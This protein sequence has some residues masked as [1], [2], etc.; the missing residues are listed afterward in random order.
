MLTT[1]PSPTLVNDVRFGYAR[2]AIGV[3]T[4]NQTITNTSVGL[5]PFGSNPRD[6]G[7]SV[8]SISGVSP[9][10]DDYTTP[11][12][13]ATDSFQLVDA[14]SWSRGA[15]LVK[16]GGEWTA[17][18]QRAFRDVQ[19]RGFL[20]FVDRG[21]S[22]NA[23]ADVLLGLPALT[24]G[25]TLDNPQRL[26]AMNWG[27]FVQDEWRATPS[28]SISA[29]VRYDYAA[30]PVDADDRASLYDPATSG[31]VPV[32]SGVPRGGYDPDRN[33]V[34]PR[35]GF[36]WALDRDAVNVLRG[37]Y[38]IYLNVGALVPSEGPYFNP[39]DFVPGVFFPAPGLP[40]PTPRDLLPA[41]CP[42][43]PPSAGR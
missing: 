22:G 31:L 41:C 36:A 3:T 18:R 27:M 42:P 15:H 28:L 26:R 23:L 19:S 39:P 37:G 30:P 32:G 12:E 4:A 8:I 33:N 14:A 35:A 13:S 21:F 6:A 17:T 24:G 9:L 11:Q 38:G 40:P 25:A 29:G 10:G 5:P 2:T 16:F 43:V 7:L 20:N 34:A 1:A